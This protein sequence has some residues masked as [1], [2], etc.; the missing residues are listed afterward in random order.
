[1]STYDSLR[2]G[3]CTGNCR[4]QRC[5]PASPT[6]NTSSYWNNTDVQ[7]NNSDDEC[8]SFDDMFD[9][10]IYATTQRSFGRP[11]HQLMPRSQ[12]HYTQLVQ[13]HVVQRPTS[14]TTHSG[15]ALRPVFMG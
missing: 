6:Y 2:S 13:R 10:K 5:T 1:M 12:T 3:G 7:R 11:G 9:K 4:T 8:T 15:Y 14:V